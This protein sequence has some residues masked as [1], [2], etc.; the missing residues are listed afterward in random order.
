MIPERRIP[1]HPGVVLR[2]EFLTPAGDSQ[3]AFAARLGIP[4]QRVNEIVKGKRG[5]TADTAWRFALAL[6]TTPEFWM[7][8]QANRDLA[9]ARPK[10]VKRGGTGRAAKRVSK[11]ASRRRG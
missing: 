8:L 1:T 10:A 3:T 4:L 11:A 6:G 7:N 5:V 9:V 2:D